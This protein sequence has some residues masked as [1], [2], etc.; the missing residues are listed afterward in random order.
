MTRRR[1]ILT[2]AGIALG[3]PVLLLAGLIAFRLPLLTR[4][5]PYGL[6]AAGL[7]PGSATVAVLDTDHLEMRDIRLAG[8][9]ITL[10]RL[11]A[12][13]TLE[14]LLDGHVDRVTLDGAQ[15]RG[16]T[17]DGQLHFP[18]LEALAGEAD[19]SAPTAVLPVLPFSQL[20]VRDSSLALETPAGPVTLTVTGTLD[21]DAADDKDGG[22][23]LH[24]TGAI[25][26]PLATGTL[27]AEGVLGADGQ[28]RRMDGSVTLSTETLSLPGL[29][30]QIRADGALEARYDG[31]RLTVT[32]NDTRVRVAAPDPALTTRL[33]AGLP[34]ALLPALRPLAEG[35]FSL[36]LTAGPDG[37]PATVILDALPNGPVRFSGS[38]LLTAPA[39]RLDAAGTMASPAA[40]VP[41]E[42]QAITGEGRLTLTA[43]ALTLPGLVDGLSGTLR[44]TVTGT[45]DGAI[46]V[47]LPAPA[48]LSVAALPALPPWLAPHLPGP[49]SA[50]LGDAA[51]AARPPTRLHRSADGRLSGD[52]ALSLATPE[53]AR[54]AVILRGAEATPEAPVPALT[55]QDLLLT[56][57]GVDRI[58][59]QGGRVAL[60][61]NGVRATPDSAEA[62]AALTASA[63]ELDEA[64]VLLAAPA[65]VAD[66]RVGWTAEA[67]LTVA[68]AS[69][70]LTATD[71]GGFGATL[72][73]PALHLTGHGHLPSGGRAPGGAD[74]PRI[75]LETLSAEVAGGRLAPG[76]DLDE[77][78]S[79]V[80]TEPI[81]LSPGTSGAWLEAPV[82]LSPDAL[83]ITLDGEPVVLD[84]GPMRLDAHWPPTPERPLR[85]RTS[86]GSLN[87]YGIR[88][89]DLAVEATLSPAGPEARVTG[90]LWSLPEEDP[91]AARRQPTRPFSLSATLGPPDTPEAERL[92]VALS[93]RG[94]QGRVDAS[95]SGSISRTGD[96]AQLTLKAK[97]ITLGV[98]KVLPESLHTALT[99]AVESITGTV[100]AQ[101]SLRYRDGRLSPSIDLMLRNVNATVQGIPL[102]DINTVLPIRSL[103]PPA[104]GTAEVSI[105]SVD[106][107][108]PVTDILAS[109]RL[110]GPSILK[111]DQATL[112]LGSGRLTTEDVT[113]PLSGGEMLIP[114][115]VDKIDLAAVA[116]LTSLKGLSAQGTVSGRIPLRVTPQGALWVDTATLTSDGPG[117][118]AYSPPS[119][120]ETLASGNAGV[121][122]ALQVLEQLKYDTLTVSLNG[123][124]DGT[125]KVGLSIEGH[126]PDVYDGYPIAFNLTLTGALGELVRQNVRAYTIPD[127]IQG[128]IDTFLEHLGVTPPATGGQ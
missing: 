75:S 115:A 89:E 118:I 102:T 83:R 2:G 95:L 123:D 93:L 6:D 3:L 120:P 98:G 41:L 105:G 65:V 77:P 28:P 66:G 124:T 69:A 92:P 99:G 35:P 108:L 49:L 128:N 61:L 32:T 18:L 116:A 101:G 45:A 12:T 62:H 17:R 14:G 40:S 39:L 55:A 7:G 94:A 21:P 91:A 26:G 43:E 9:A 59:L 90:A 16:L 29:A 74:G 22:H 126:N 42:A 97:P 11:T 47:T 81:V 104:S 84:P 5:V 68:G 88:L 23:A 125:L 82:A 58:G 85:L 36:S 107:G 100:A 48:R 96:D 73:N 112:S 24:L 67:G 122:L 114:L 20:V 110:A 19:P 30:G 34:P 25:T 78:L 109:Y 113:I 56:I 54:A 71:F 63:R 46:D 80:L 86:G 64:G 121:L 31:G 15:T 72:A 37:A 103:T 51:D 117:V 4:A 119:D 38:A 127:R 70:T 33:T 111:L 52:L 60:L 76:V 53:G 87:G 27:A 13:W 79:L 10:D 44:A 106:I 57:E 50:S 1:R 8:G